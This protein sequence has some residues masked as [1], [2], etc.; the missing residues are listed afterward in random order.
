MALFNNQTT[1][2]DENVSYG[3]FS[4]NTQ[5]N[6]H[7]MQSAHQEV[8]VIY[9]TLQPTATEFHPLNS[10]NGAIR[11][12]PQRHSYNRPK[13]TRPNSYGSGRTFS[14]SRGYR[15][16]NERS[17]DTLFE[18]QK[19]SENDQQNDQY[20]NSVGNSNSYYNQNDGNV[21]G[22]ANTSPNSTKYLN[23]YNYQNEGSSNFY[24][25]N[26]YSEDFS[27]SGRNFDRYNRSNF[28][29]KSENFPSN[30]AVRKGYNY[31]FAKKSSYNKSYK[32]KSRYNTPQSN[33]FNRNKMEQDSFQSEQYSSVDRNNVNFKSSYKSSSDG[34]TNNKFSRQNVKDFRNQSVKKTERNIVR[35]K[36][37]EQIKNILL[38]FNSNL[39]Y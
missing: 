39:F 4:N 12:E 7:P 8:N 30:G 19:F 16:K 37:G 26:N 23:N 25:K 33:G 13:S 24:S 38:T 2:I 27:G 29:S 17:E 14:N 20:K 15:Q 22:Y 32:D 1:Y 5:M 21:R 9:S 3:Q 18:R 31:N 34:F 11:K 36:K 28:S 35:I 6:S 10:S